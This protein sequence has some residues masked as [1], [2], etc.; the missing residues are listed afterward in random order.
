MSKMGRPKSNNIMDKSYTIRMDDSTLARLEVYCN[1]MQMAKSE[2]I[3]KAINKMI[4]D[5]DDS[6]NEV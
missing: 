1:H 3:R 2:A 6:E 4:D 5:V